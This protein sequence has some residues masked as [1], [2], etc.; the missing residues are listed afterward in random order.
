MRLMDKD[1]RATAWTVFQHTIPYDN[2]HLS[3]GLGAGGRA[4]TIPDPLSIGH[5]VIYIGPHPTMALLIHELTHVWQGH[6]SNLAW[7]YILNS[8][9]SQMVCKDAYDYD[10]KLEDD[11][12]LYNV[13]QQASIVENWYVDGRSKTDK[14]YRYIRDNILHP[15]KERFSSE[16]YDGILK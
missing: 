4:F 6:N 7:G 10:K 8:L 11:W 12:R 16:D 2:V 5:Y 9:F 13:E 15:E 14:A 1:E 3:S